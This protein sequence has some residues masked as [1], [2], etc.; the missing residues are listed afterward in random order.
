MKGKVMFRRNAAVAVLAMALVSAG[1]SVA[2][3]APGQACDRAS[4]RG[5]G[6]VKACAPYT[7]RVEARVNIDPRTGTL[8][9]ACRDGFIRDPEGGT[10]FGGL[11][12]FDQAGFVSVTGTDQ[13]PTSYSITYT[14]ATSAPISFGGIYLETLCRRA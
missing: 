14:M 1:G 2:N 11:V 3:A 5:V 8:T 4:D 12:P 13:T 7:I 6:H 10:S 9:V